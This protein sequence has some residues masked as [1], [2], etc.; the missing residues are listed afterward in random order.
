M[1]CSIAHAGDTFYSKSYNT[2]IDASGGA[3]FKIIDCIK[4]E[5]IKQ[6]KRLNAAY[7]KL[8]LQVSPD[9]KKLLVTAQRLWIQYRDANCS[10][11]YDPDGGSV[12]RING[13]ACHLEMT[14]QRANE[15]ENLAK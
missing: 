8:G 3:T 5:H 6:D 12:A 1:M 13:V 11:Y 7:K 2:C 4:D 14:A 9:Q 15:L 10:F